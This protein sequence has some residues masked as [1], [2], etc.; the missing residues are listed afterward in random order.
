MFKNYLVTA[1]KVLQRRKFFTFISLFGITITL[2]V[3]MILSTVLDNFLNPSG[4]SKNSDHLLFVDRIKVTSKDGN[5]NWTS[6]PGFRFLKDN[7]LK[8]KMPEKFSIFTV[9]EESA[10]YLNGDKVTN[11]LR[12]TDSTYWEVL[13]FNFIEGH[14]FNKQELESGKKVAVINETTRRNFFG[15]ANAVGKSIEINSQK[16]QVVGV[17]RDVS[18]MEIQAYSDIWL[19]YTTSSSTSYRSNLIDNWNA[20]LYHSN[21][22]MIKSMQAEYIAMLKNDFVTPDPEEFHKVEGGADTLL[23][24]FA[25]EFTSSYGYD[26]GAAS[27]ISI[28]IG[29]TISFMLLPSINLI[30]LNISRIMER[31]SEIGVRK[32]FGASTTQLVIQFV[33]ENIIITAIG[34]ILG[35]LLSGL[36]LFQIEQSG[37]VPGADFRYS[38]HTFIYGSGLIFLFGLL[39]GAYP[40]FKMSKLHPVAALKGGSN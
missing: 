33:T 7:V 2:T 15:D 1:W 29:L 21:S 34:G 14:P 18:F 28:L 25:R 19:P 32:A 20:I 24:I 12:L 40:A 22:N 4:P 17:V 27:L 31:S 23:D 39:S 9:I 11:H 38:W 16:Y 8:L 35:L 30:N 26:S 36:I 37:L 13:D 3:L 5:S 10:S 6:Q